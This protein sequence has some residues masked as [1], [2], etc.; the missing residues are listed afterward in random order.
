MRTPAKNFASLEKLRL[1]VM[2]MVEEKVAYELP[3]SMNVAPY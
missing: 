1:E 2:A 3:V